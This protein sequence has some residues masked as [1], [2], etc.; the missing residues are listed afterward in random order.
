MGYADDLT[1]ASLHERR[2]IGKRNVRFDFEC[3]FARR[4]DIRVC[5]GGTSRN[6]VRDFGHFGNDT[7]V[8]IGRAFVRIK[9]SDVA[10]IQIQ[11]GYAV[12]DTE[13]D[14]L[15]LRAVI[16]SFI[17][18]SGKRPSDGFGI[19]FIMRKRAVRDDNE[20]EFRSFARFLLTAQHVH[21]FG[22]A[23]K[24]RSS[25]RRGKV[26]DHIHGIL[27]RTVRKI[28]GN[29]VIFLVHI[30]NIQF[31]LRAEHTAKGLHGVIGVDESVF[32]AHTARI[33][34]NDRDDLFILRN[35]CRIHIRHEQ[36]DH[37]RKRKQKTAKRYDFFH[38]MFPFFQV[39]FQV[40]IKY[41][42]YITI[43][44]R[45]R[46]GLSARGDYFFENIDV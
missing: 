23:I 33:V 31:I 25:V 30:G 1:R 26:A 28:N 27:K 17:R 44:F 22:Y 14:D 13:I 37:T 7:V 8:L 6:D 19:G 46:Q 3:F 39:Y 36:T 29:G 9:F 40:H 18:K 42:I 35:V 38:D 21:R 43:F 41:I 45:F 5:D 4:F 32:T 12:T 11:F 15:R 34:I 24:G 2:D 16:H 20:N 10:H